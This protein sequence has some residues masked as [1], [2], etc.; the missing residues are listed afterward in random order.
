M[1]LCS[2]RYFLLAL[3]V[4]L[5]FGA[6][7]K[8]PNRGL[9][10]GDA[11]EQAENKRDD[12]YVRIVTGDRINVTEQQMKDTVRRTLTALR[13]GKYFPDPFRRKELHERMQAFY[14][15]RSYRLA[16]NGNEGLLPQADSLLAALGTAHAEG[17]DPRNYP[18]DEIE[19]LRDRLF[20]ADATP[21]T[22]QLEDLLHLDLL[23][24][25]TYLTYARHLTSG[26]VNPDD[27]S[28]DWYFKL[29]PKDYVQALNRGLK[30][31]RVQRSL[32]ALRPELRQYA[33]LLEQLAAYRELAE[34]GGWPSVPATEEPLKLGDT[35]PAVGVLK[36]RLLV[37]GELDE[38]TAWAVDT[39]VFDAGLAV[40]VATFQR[41]QGT[42]VDSAVG[43][44]TLE[45]LNV[46]AERRVL[47]IELNLER[48]RWLPEDLGDRY[49]LVNIPEYMLH[50]W[51]EGERT[52]QT[53]VVVGK[54]FTSE[55]PIFADTM[56]YVVLSPTWNV[57]LSIGRDEMLPK[58]RRDPSWLSR[59]NYDLYASWAA[60]APKIDP[61]SVDWESVS[62]ADFNYKVVQRPGGGNALGRAKF[63][64]P[65]NLSIYLH[66]TPSDHLF[67]REER[68]FSHGCVRVEEPA[69]LAAYLLKPNGYDRSRVEEEMYLTEEKWVTMK[70]IYPVN[71]VYRTAWVDEATGE[72][73]FARDVYG[74]DD[75]Q[76]NLIRQKEQGMT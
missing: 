19:A 64:F 14:E 27:L 26:R 5:L 62:P 8:S 20:G 73:R 74:Y 45:L 44:T 15:G 30:Q 18:T 1:K 31:N 21:E 50:I 9:S 67:A 43:P 35:L 2:L 48:L 33:L 55:T 60:D 47:E 51:E 3:P 66:D 72:M 4:V 42:S 58:L 11:I 16:W 29:Q 65:N 56:K 70:K 12:E 75:A 57:P 23:L 37:T 76:L 17:L 36:R 6:C 52:F 46:P 10:D 59:N 71:I 7:R 39:N 61:A 28:E 38:R 63:L 34:A 13:P 54:G 49:L 24:T 41:L 32:V 68:D 40:A 69:R 53:R 25:G 22:V